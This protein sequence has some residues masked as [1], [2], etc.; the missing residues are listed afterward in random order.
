MDAL[1][2]FTVDDAFLG[3]YVRLITG[4]VI[5]YQEDILNDRIPG[6]EKSHAVENY[7]LAAEVNETGAC[8]SEFYGMVF[9]DSDIAKWLE[10]AA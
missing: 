4:T 8:S 6:V 1:K 10:A 3:R 9:Q 7:R 2:L 5:P